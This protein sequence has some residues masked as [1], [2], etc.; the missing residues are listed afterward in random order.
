LKLASAAFVL[1][2]LGA[3]GVGDLNQRLGEP[4]SLLR[5]G[6]QGWLGYLLFVS[7][8]LVGLSYTV[9]L[10]RAGK[11][12]EA[13]SAGLATLLLFLVAVTPSF[14]GFHLLCSF[15]LLLLLFRHFWRLLRESE[16]LWLFPHMQAPLALVFVTGGHSYGLWQKGLILYIVVLSNIHHHLLGRRLAGRPLATATARM[17]GGGGVNG[18]RKS[19]RLELGRGWARQNAR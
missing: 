11:E 3:H 2:L 7:L 9:A 15:G 16:S 10:I 12:G 17:F 13:V 18:R 4:L 5:D 8:L 1:L 19:Y 6:E 14:Q